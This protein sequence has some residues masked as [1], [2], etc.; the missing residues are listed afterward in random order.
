[1]ENRKFSLCENFLFSIAQTLVEN[2]P[3]FL[4]HNEISLAAPV[5][6]WRLEFKHLKREL[7]DGALI[8][9]GCFFLVQQC[10]FM[11]FFFDQ[12]DRVKLLHK[13]IYS[14]FLCDFFFDQWD[15]V[16]LLPKTIYFVFLCDFFSDQWDRVKLLHKTP[17]C[18]FFSSPIT[19]APE[20]V[21][22]NGVARIFC[23]AFYYSPVEKN[24]CELLR[25]Q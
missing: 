18:G 15:R 17:P 10:N 21:L 16:K 25:C 13:T 8:F 6:A 7:F 9:I 22:T 3:H 12:W 1:M 2:L 24:A 5:F 4:V 19:I 11:R 20:K 23:A 14:V